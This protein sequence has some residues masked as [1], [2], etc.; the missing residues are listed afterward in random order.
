[1]SSSVTPLRILHTLCRIG[2]GGVEQCRLQLARVLPKEEYVHAL[3]CQDTAGAVPNQLRQEGW[4]IHEIGL[5]PHILDLHWHAKALAIARNFSPD[6]IHGAVYEG[7][8]I[9]TGLGLRMRGVKVIAEETSDPVNRRWTGTLLMR[10]MLA[11]SDACIGVSPIVTDYLI[12]KLRVPRRKVHLVNNA[13]AE[14]DPTSPQELD[15]LRRTLG[16]TSAHRGVGT[17]G[18]LED[19]HKRVSAIIRALPKV[20]SDHPST[21]LLIIGDGHDRQMLEDL[22]FS[23]DVADAVVFAGYQGNPRPFYEL[24]DIFVLASAHE[25]FGL[26]LVEAMLARTPVIAT[27]VGGIPFVLDEGRAGVLVPSFSSVELAV[28]INDLL[29]N[30]RRRRSL[31]AAGIERAKTAFS[32]DRYCL[33][34]DN[35]YRC[36]AMQKRN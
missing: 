36:L 9:A 19:G 17:V 3:I 13:V 15:Q 5:A 2:S 30:A 6:I 33:E 32:V 22:A 7:I 20:L 12:H 35:L 14:V 23:L 28:A 34:I 1:M 21:R 18:R 24:M 4:E 31:S 27:R 26:V 10:A 25:A 16:I 8:A 29:R 11:R